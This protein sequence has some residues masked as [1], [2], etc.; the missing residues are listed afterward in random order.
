MPT[1]KGMYESA[2]R[3]EMSIV[4]DPHYEWLERPES[5]RQHSEEAI[6][7]AIDIL[8]GNLKHPRAGRYSASSMGMCKRRV[9]F[10]YQGA[11]ENGVSTDTQNLM[12]MGTK[13]H[14]FWQLEG[15]TMGWMT[16]AE[17]WTYSS[18]NNVGGS[19][20]GVLYDDS[21]FEL[22][23]AHPSVYSRIV[24]KDHEPKA[25]HQLQF[26]AYCLNSG[27]QNGSIV[28]EDR[29]TGQFHEFRVRY[30]NQL[31][32]RVLSYIEDVNDYRKRDV[33]PQVLDDC[34]QRK[35]DTFKQCP[36]RDHCLSQP[37]VSQLIKRP[38]I[39]PQPVDVITHTEGNPFA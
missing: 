31:E 22:K 1:L 37:D 3:G 23:T 2:K 33:L 15:I 7:V 13:H 16:E 20:D 17:V 38:A 12:D 32:D 27:R 36:F 25:E 30:D 8:R 6:A 10:G 34:E 14:L 35:G 18:D 19:I 4:T 24:T 29:A 21:V 9:I 5:E 28:Y 26:G 11:P 39:Q